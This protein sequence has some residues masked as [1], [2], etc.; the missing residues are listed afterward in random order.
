MASEYLGRFDVLIRLHDK[1]FPSLRDRVVRPY[2]SQT[3]SDDCHQRD[4]LIIVC[5]LAAELLT[6]LGTTSEQFGEDRILKVNTVK[7]RTHS[8][9]RQGHFYYQAMETWPCE[10]AARL[11]ARFSLLLSQHDWPNF[12]FG[13][14]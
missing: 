3:Y 10:R 8:L 1:P 14:V 12:A 4:R 13:L 6:L 9:F 7:Y 2:L 11:L 5:A